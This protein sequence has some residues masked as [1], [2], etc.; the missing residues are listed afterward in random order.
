MTRAKQSGGGWDLNT[1]PCTYVRDPKTGAWKPSRD[2][3]AVI[4][5]TAAIDAPADALVV[6]STGRWFR[7]PSGERVTLTTRRALRLMLKA[8]ADRRALAPGEA[9]V[10]EQLI[11]AGWP[12]EE[13]RPDAGATRVYAALSTLRKL[14]LREI[15][16]RRDDG[17][18][19]DPGVPLVRAREA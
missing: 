5:E 11:E 1:T 15:L 3:A 12:G 18:L 13:V 9:L 7:P 2:D 19:L 14:G 8:L 6:A 17:Y 4:D 16:V 10:L